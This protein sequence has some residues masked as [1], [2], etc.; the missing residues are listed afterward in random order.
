MKRNLQIIV[1]FSLGIFFSFN[2]YSQSWSDVAY[3]KN[4]DTV[5][6]MGSNQ[7]NIYNPIAIAVLGD[8]ISTGERKNLNRVYETIP[9][10]M[11]IS[12]VTC[13]LDVTVPLLNITAPLPPDGVMPPV[14]VRAIKDDGTFDKT[15]F[16]T[17]G[18]TYMENQ[19]FE[20]ATINNTYEEREFMRC[21][22]KASHHEYH[23]VV[24]EM[25]NWTHHVPF[26]TNQ[27]YKY[28]DCKFINVGNEATL[29]KGCV[30]ETRT[31]PPDTVWFENCTFLNGGIFVLGL[32]TT[33][34]MFVYVNHNTIVN[35]VQ[36]PLCFSTGA[37]MVVTNNLFVNAGMVA[38][39][40]TFYPL[41]NDDDLLP[42]GLINLDTMEDEWI[43]NWYLDENGES[44]YPVAEADRKVL[45]YNNNAWWDP[46]FE[47]MID[48]ILPTEKPISSDIGNYE[49]TS[50]MILMNNRTKTMF[51]DSISYPY[52]N[53]GRN[54]N[55]EPDF[56]NNK[57]FVDD[58]VRFVVV[59]STLG[60]M[61]GGEMMPRWRT[62]FPDSIYI[63]DW[64]MLAD[65]SYTNSTLLLGGLNKFPLGDL[66]WFPELKAQWEISSE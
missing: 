9:G 33:G 35:C 14:H 16:K 49:W 21:M 2:I 31:L 25:T 34:P 30:L 8:T 61:C 12:D 44:F 13:E 38:D 20:L 63:P 41:F 65:L 27:T 37:E 18:N 55:I 4:H 40:P 7:H 5:V 19:F 52:L 6:I 58:W 36:P 64:P 29:E 43:Q 39:F 60:A 11:Y 66:N 42:K 50:Q 59:N 51:D 26:A 24:W 32:E 22:G 62:H 54:F 28:I 10:D 47:T 46:R 56:L 15:F 45:F 23:N 53:E 3:E 1:F 17:P 57:D 48:S